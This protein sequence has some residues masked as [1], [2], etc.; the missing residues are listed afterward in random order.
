MEQHSLQ[1]TE[2]FASK[3]VE[4]ADYAFSFGTDSISKAQKMRPTDKWNSLEMATF[5]DKCREGFKIAQKLLVD[6]VISYQQI[7]KQNKAKIKEAR[8]SHNKKKTEELLNLNKVIV[9]RL[10]N[11]SHIADGLAIQMMGQ[12]VHIARRLHIGEKS[13]KLL[14]NSNIEHAIKEADKL[15][16][17]SGNFALISDLTSFIQIGDLL[18]ADKKKGLYITELKEGKTNEKIRKCIDMT[19]ENGG[20]PCQSF[21]SSFSE[22]E[23]KQM[24]R[25]LRQDLRAQQATE[26]IN[27]DKG[28]DVAT[29]LNITINTP[30]I[31]LVYYDGIFLN[32]LEEL[33]TKDWSYR[34]LEDCLHIGMYQGQIGQPMA[35]AT[36]PFILKRQAKNHM[37][38]DLMQITE[39]LSETLFAKPL[40]KEFV[41]KIMT[42]QAKII[43]GIDLDELINT[44]NANGLKTRW[45]TTK[46]TAKI[47]SKGKDMDIITS[48]NRAI[49]IELRP[50]VEG[51]MSG[52]IIS[53]IAFDNILPSNLAASMASATPPPK[54]EK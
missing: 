17:Y 27:T 38:I 54:S 14:E 28:I 6:E 26:V 22:T 9:R 33:K 53:K 11:L 29:G 16:E 7:L 12:Q 42:G 20:I 50:G 15:N 31:D 8:T 36:I 47:K 46:E 23:H 51:V 4:I 10:H 24:Q 43:I 3:L 40:P 32:M 41:V 52:G 19:L 45:L 34:V 44:F 39:Q 1:T 48:K 30:T 2:Q 37:V 5:M 21:Q 18:V 49:G 25:M 35:R 13:T